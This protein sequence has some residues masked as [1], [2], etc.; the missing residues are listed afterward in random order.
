MPI[1]SG[2]KSSPIPSILCWSKIIPLDISGILSGSMAVSIKFG[3]FSLSFLP[4]PI[5]VPPVPTP[6]TKPLIGSESWFNISS[7][8]V[9]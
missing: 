8:V 1:N 5:K 4:V 9:S 2:I 6:D 3:Y 7:P